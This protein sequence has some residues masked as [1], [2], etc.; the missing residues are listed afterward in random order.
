MVRLGCSAFSMGTQG[1][2]PQSFYPKNSGHES[3]PLKTPP[4]TNSCEVV[5]NNWI[6]IFLKIPNPAWLAPRVL[7]LSPILT[8]VLSFSFLFL[9]LQISPCSLFASVSSNHFCSDSR[10]LY[11][12]IAVNVGDSRS[13]LI[14]PGGLS[15]PLTADHK[16]NNLE[17]ITRIQQA[18]G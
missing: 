18:G 14:S 13:L 4:T 17:E 12:V 11:V 1:R 16:P 15:K 9:F 2:L 10:G 6:A 7:S 8:K 3:P 5:C